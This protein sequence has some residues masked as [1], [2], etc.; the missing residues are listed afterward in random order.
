MLIYFIKGSLPW[1]GIDAMTKEE[2]YNKIGDVKRK[3]T[4]EELCK[5]LPMELKVFIDYCCGLEFAE[6]PNYAL[7]F[8]LLEKIYNQE[9]E[10]G[11]ENLDWDIKSNLVTR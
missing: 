5:D 3:I 9:G 6:T 7:L 8:K 2:K 11:N 10:D 1:Q 4:I